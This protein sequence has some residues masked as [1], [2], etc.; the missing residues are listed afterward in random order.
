MKKHLLDVC[1]ILLD[2]FTNRYHDYDGYWGVGVLYTHAKSLN[3]TFFEF[4][5]LGEYSA[6]QD[7]FLLQV[8]QNFQ[9][10]LVHYLAI[11]QKKLNNLQVANIEINF[12]DQCL[13]KEKTL[14]GHYFIV[15]VKIVDKE[16]RSFL[17]EAN[18]YCVPHHDW[19]NQRNYIDTLPNNEKQFYWDVN[20]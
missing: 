8:Q 19:T 2:K 15:K 3:S 5:L 9:K 16:G 1:R 6:H 20:L 11:H 10:Y 13:I 18:G 7:L 14:Y 12:D 17:A 4:N